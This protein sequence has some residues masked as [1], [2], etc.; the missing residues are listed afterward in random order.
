MTESNVSI[1]AW[2]ISLLYVG[3][4]TFTVLCL[5]P[6]APLGGDWTVGGVFYTLPVSIWGAT[7]VRYDPSLFPFALCV[8]VGVFFLFK[9]L[10]KKGL[11]YYT[12][13]TAPAY[14]QYNNDERTLFGTLSERL[15]VYLLS[16]L[17]DDKRCYF[18]Q[19]QRDFF[20]DSDQKI[21]LFPDKLS[22]QKYLLVNRQFRDL[23][24]W[25]NAVAKQGYTRID[26]DLD[27]LKTDIMTD[28]PMSTQFIIDLIHE[29]ATQ[30]KVSTLI[31]IL[32]NDVFDQFEEY[33]KDY[34]IWD[35]IYDLYPEFETATFLRLCGELHAG[36]R[37]YLR[38]DIV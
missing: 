5:L 31:A 10:L 23:K 7:I 8:Q 24:E 37:D 17:I 34:Y 15:E 26:Y 13:Y 12:T 9:W 19:I 3:F 16:I 30:Y 11:K 6:D 18:V 1:N 25:V 28:D 14:H 22:L 38:I 27:L 29:Y 35:S 21:P 36:F 20:T 33:A 2:V 32:N 4:G